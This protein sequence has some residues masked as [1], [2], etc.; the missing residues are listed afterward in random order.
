M[1]DFWITP[2]NK[3]VLSLKRRFTET[4]TGECLYQLYRGYARYRTRTLNVET[5]SI[6]AEHA[7][8]HS[9]KLQ[10]LEIERLIPSVR[11]VTFNLLERSTLFTIVSSRNYSHIMAVYDTRISSYAIRRSH[12]LPSRFETQKY[13]AALWTTTRKPAKRAFKIPPLKIFRITGAW[14]TTYVNTEDALKT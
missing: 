14:Q 13:Y 11:V 7:R 5:F 12:V 8:L 4:I 10:R 1:I 2:P 9:R 6:Y 3:D